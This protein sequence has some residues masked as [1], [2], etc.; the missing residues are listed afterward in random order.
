MDWR[1]GLSGRG[2]SL[3][4]QS[5]EFKLQSYPPPKKDILYAFGQLYCYT[6]QF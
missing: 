4:V 1:C 3:Q 5:P 2:P 6:T